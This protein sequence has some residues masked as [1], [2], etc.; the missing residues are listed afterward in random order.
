MRERALD[1]RNRNVLIMPVPGLSLAWQTFFGGVSHDRDWWTPQAGFRPGLPLDT[2]GA[3]VAE[4]TL[5]F[6][7]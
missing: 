3:M 6:P 5:R 7:P 1:E 2:T 4:S